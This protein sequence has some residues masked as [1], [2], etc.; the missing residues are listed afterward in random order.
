MTLAQY[1]HDHGVTA[2]AQTSADSGSI[3]IAIQQPPGWLAYD[4]FQLPNTYAVLTDRRAIDQNFAPNA[5][6]MVHKLTGG[7]DP[8]QAILRGL[9]DTQRYKNFKQAQASLADFS[10]YPSAVIEGS[11]DDNADPARRLHVRNR[12]VLAAKGDQNYL[13]L[14]SVTTTEA[15]SSQLAQDLETL[16][17][18]I[19][20]SFDP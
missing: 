6:V 18:G 10:G 20:I 9:V 1:L 15:Q 8:R 2:Q 14:V 19:K 12:Y 16:T 11:F 17:D 13:I 5:V 7:F 4:A 3:R